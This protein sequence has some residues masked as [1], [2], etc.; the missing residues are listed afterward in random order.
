MRG[1]DFVEELKA[2]LTIA[3]VVIL[4]IVGSRKLGVNA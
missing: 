3:V 2:S 1:G 4:V